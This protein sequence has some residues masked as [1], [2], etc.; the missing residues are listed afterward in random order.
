MKFKP[1]Q[2]KKSDINGN[3]PFETAIYQRAY[4][5]AQLVWQ[6]AIDVKDWSQ[7]YF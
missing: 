1:I 4:S 7:G 5:A 3:S 2:L 6:T